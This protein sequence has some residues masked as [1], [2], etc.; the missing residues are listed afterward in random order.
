MKSSVHEFVF[1]NV[2][3][4]HGGRNLN[5]LVLPVSRRYASEDKIQFGYFISSQPKHVKARPEHL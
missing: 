3:E 1:S 4:C 5:I 2:E